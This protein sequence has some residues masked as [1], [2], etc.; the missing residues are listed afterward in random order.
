MFTI[1]S[2]PYL[3]ASSPTNNMRSGAGT[4]EPLLGNSRAEFQLKKSGRRRGYEFI[5]GN[6]PMGYAYEVFTIVL[7]VLNVLAFVLA[8]QLDASVP[9]D[10]RWT[11]SWCGVWWSGDDSLPGNSPVLELLTM[12]V[13]TVD[14]MVRFWATQEDAKEH[15]SSFYGHVRY[16]F[17]FFSL[18]DLVSILPFYIDLI[19]TSTDIPA[20]QFFRMFRLFR[21]MRV[22][23]Y[24]EA[25]TLF[26]DVLLNN[27]H[28][29]G[30]AGFVGFATWVIIAALYYVAERFNAEM[31]YCPSILAAQA[32]GQCLDFD[33]AACTYDAF[34][35]VVAASCGTN[36]AGAQC[37]NLFESILSSMYFTL[38]NLFGE[39][40]LADKHAGWGRVVAAFTAIVAVAV[41]AIPTG[42]VGNGFNDMLEER[43]DARAKEEARAR[44]QKAQ[45]RVL[46][47]AAFGKM[48]SVNMHTEEVS[49]KPR[50]ESETVGD[51]RTFRGRLF[52]FLHAKS[53]SGVVFEYSIFFL[54]F[55]NVLGFLFETVSFVKDDKGTMD[56]FEA[57]EFFSVLVFTIEY[58]LRLYAVGEVELYG[59]HPVWGRLSWMTSFYAMVDLVSIAPWY[60]SKILPLGKN[61]TTFVRSLRLLRMLKAEQYN[62]AFTVLDDVVRA[63]SDV[64]VVTGF[65]AMVLW[66]FFS[67]LMYYAERNNPDPEMREYYFSIPDAMWMTL[68]NLSGESPVCN[69]TAWGKLITGFIGIVGCGVFGIPIGIMGAG[70]EDWVAE[71]EEEKAKAREGDESP[72]DSEQLTIDMTD[73]DE[74]LGPKSFRRRV[75]DLVEAKTTSGKY[76]EAFIFLL[77]FA[78]IVTTS[79]QTVESVG[80]SVTGTSTIRICEI[81]DS[82]EVVAVIIF[83]M[84]YLLRLYSVPEDPDYKEYKSGASKICRYVFSFYSIIDLLAILPF[85]L[86]FAIPV[87][88]KYDNYLRL[89]RILRLFKLDK[90]VPSISLLDD[91]LRAKKDPLIVTGFC[92]GVITIIF[93]ALLYISE[94][95]DTVN[96]IDPIPNDGCKANCT[97]ADRFK[98]AFMAIPLAVIHLSGDYPIVNY[99]TWARVLNFFGVI[100]GVGLVSIPAGLIANGFSEVVEEN[101]AAHTAHPDIVKYTLPEQVPTVVFDAMATKVHRFLNATDGAGKAF[102]GVIFVLIVLNV[103]AVVLETIPGI[104]EQWGEHNFNIFEAFSVI[105][106]T[107]EYLLR[108]FSVV[109]DREHFYSRY[110]YCTTF[111]GIVDLLAILPWYIQVIFF[112][113]NASM[114][115]IFR[116]FRLFR[117]LQLEHFCEAFTLLDDVYRQSENV[118]KATGLM[119]LIIWLLSGVLF[120]LFESN[121]PNWCK[122]NNCDQPNANPAFGDIPSALYYTAIFLGGEWAKT[123]FTFGGKVLCILLVV[124]GIGIYSIPIGSLF[125]AFGDVIGGGDDDEGN[126]DESDQEFG[127]AIYR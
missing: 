75:Y 19:D 41:F 32:K 56:F 108:V 59:Y 15:P 64:L 43:R 82:F 4:A 45:G 67:V 54:I 69:F 121:N 79:I 119:A 6:T 40:P 46:A 70:F 1:A 88:D 99:D 39:F 58:L 7:I 55:L 103:C 84:E 76:F 47:A 117:V 74:G 101:Q 16:I 34:G 92:A 29:L 110:F 105:V 42:I 107:I 30:V 35:R 104:N 114:A 96:Q 23:R 78:S 5:E 8:S 91:V 28:V 65:T 17:S 18:V 126:E 106:F 36:C 100:I 25:F 53:S 122:D 80:C 9:D 72:E 51:R 115:V 44:F 63:Q 21:M 109:K 20:S 127:E 24:H 90:Y 13:F 27:A 87:L 38:L 77:I 89:C 61:G 94:M 111:F 113:H 81:M 68:L 11:C 37:Y 120:Y 95:N 85:Y 48:N 124:V 60:F 50:G 97:Q 93:S 52:N 102:N 10:A 112:P 12:A 3:S 57:F 86:K 98:D 22:R 33:A 123:D 62:E 71:K 125:D 118:L 31:I 116:I 73:E 66:I 2:S 26:D 83:S 49:N 14:Y